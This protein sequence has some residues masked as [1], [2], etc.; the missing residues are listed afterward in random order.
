MLL[1]QYVHYIG[2]FIAGLI[3]YKKPLDGL[4]LTILFL[5][6]EIYEYNVIRDGDYTSIR[7]FLA[8]FYI[9]FITVYYINRLKRVKP[10]WRTSN[11]H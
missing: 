5:G 4:N 8:G 7:E 2:G 1:S 3:G 11:V 10:K 6:Y 9:G